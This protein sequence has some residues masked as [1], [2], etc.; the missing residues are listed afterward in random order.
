M[1]AIFSNMLSAL[2][3]VMNNSVSTFTICGIWDE[4][5]CPEEML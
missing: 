1:S 5:T 3:K 2:S 4:E